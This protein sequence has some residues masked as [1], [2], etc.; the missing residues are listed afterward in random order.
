MLRTT[1]FGMTHTVNAQIPRFT[2]EQIVR[3]I[4]TITEMTVQ[5]VPY[6]YPECGVPLHR[7]RVRVILIMTTIRAHLQRNEFGLMLTATT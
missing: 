1:D 3:D 5:R 2:D 4:G 6:L 7:Y